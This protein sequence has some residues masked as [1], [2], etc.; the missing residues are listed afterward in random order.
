[1][2]Q[3]IPEDLS[4]QIEKIASALMLSA[5]TLGNVRAVTMPAYTR[6]EMGNIIQ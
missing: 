4:P 1:M 6:E 3:E 5:G 2:P